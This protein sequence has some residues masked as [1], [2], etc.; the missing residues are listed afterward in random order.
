MLGSDGQSDFDNSIAKEANITDAVMKF[1]FLLP[2]ITTQDIVKLLET[3]NVTLTAKDTVF[4]FMNGNKVVLDELQNWNNAYRGFIKDLTLTSFGGVNS[5]L[6][7]HKLSNIHTALYVTCA[8]MGT[9]MFLGM[10]FSF[11]KMLKRRP[12]SA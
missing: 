2:N 12:G 11:T 7:G 3:E 5:A 10:V 9:S 8:V 1:L 4:S 6:S